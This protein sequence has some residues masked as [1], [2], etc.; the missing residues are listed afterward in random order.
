MSCE[1]I[2][3]EISE[4]S[5]DER[6]EIVV[7]AFNVIKRIPI[8]DIVYIFAENR[9]VKIKTEEKEY[10][11]STKLK[12]LDR[13]FSGLGFLRCH[14]S[15]LVNLEYVK[16]TGRNELHLRSGRSIPIGCS[17]RENVRSELLSYWK[18]KNY[19]FL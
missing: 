7:S 16:D 13:I 12:E 9:R 5:D 2:K 18:S 19:I 3:A 6:V 11:C 17:R 10:Y 4:V 8:S 1:G 14:K 15:F